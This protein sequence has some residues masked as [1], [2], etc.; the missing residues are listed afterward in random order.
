MTTPDPMDDAPTRIV[1][2]GGG[3]G[4][5]ALLSALKPPPP[6]E[7]GCGLWSLTAI[8][9]VS[10]NGGSSGR[11]RRTIGTLPPGDIR[12]CLVALSDAPETLR[13]LLQHRFRQG[14]LEGHSVGNLLIAG[15]A[16]MTG[17][18][19]AAVAHM[20]YILAIRGR[21]FPSTTDSVQLVAETGDGR[22][23]KGEKAIAESRSAI[24]RV[25]LEPSYC[26]ALPEARRALERADL[27]LLG[28]GSLYTS[29]LP[30]LLVPDLARS[31]ESSGA[32]K[33]YICNLVTQPGETIGLT[34]S[35][36][37]E[38]ILA[39]LPRLKIDAVLCNNTPLPE[40]LSRAYAE[41]GAEAIAIDA[42]RIEALGSSVVARDLLKTD[43]VARH[44][45]LKVRMA[46]RELLGATAT[47]DT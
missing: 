15:L 7:E 40:A 19:A 13:S 3:T 32:R 22:L 41:T 10:D 45:P 14:E 36:H 46:V 16:E 17:D 34:A 35:Q 28:P 2:L 12:N 39:H 38:A 37:L 5:P 43:T 1:A 31:L 30:N 4:L 9:T 33:V 8:V 6:G 20:H 18:F 47:K 21:I 23:V 24:R 27:I 25:A 26:S 44:D 29:V 42:R 11:L